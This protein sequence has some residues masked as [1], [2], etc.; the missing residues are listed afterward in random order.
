MIL[1]K[2]GI[3]QFVLYKYRYGIGMFALFVSAIFLL[4]IRLDTLVIGISNSEALQGLSNNSLADIVKNPLYAPYKIMQWGSIKI[5]G[6]SALALR[7][8]SV[9]FAAASVALLYDIFRHWHKQRI[10]ILGSI[11]FVTSSWFLNYARLGISSISLA[12]FILILLWAGTR[13]HHAPVRRWP[14]LIMAGTVAVSLYV[15]YMLYFLIAGVALH[16]YA[17]KKYLWHLNKK[18]RVAGLAILIVIVAPL[19]YAMAIDTNLIKLYF[20]VPLDLPSLKEYLA[21]ISETIGHIFWR[22]KENPE[23]HL[24]E[25]PMLDIF[26][27]TMA[28][29]G[30]YQYEKQLNQHRTKW[31]F[32]G[33]LILVLSLSLASLQETFIALA[34][35]TYIFAATGVV[36][37]LVQWYEI[38]PRNPV[39][40]T[41]GLIPIIML[42]MIVTSYH[43]NRY[44][45][46]WARSPETKAVFNMDTAALR[47]AIIDSPEQEIIVVAPEDQH[48]TIQFS[49]SGLV[50]SVIILTPGDFFNSNLA[51]EATYIYTG[52]EVPKEISKQLTPAGEVNSQ[53]TND[54]LSYKKFLGPD[55]KIRG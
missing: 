21:S 29:L 2:G 8:P 39:A 28:A 33:S 32:I 46:A 55:V 40:R 16:R 41:V 43:A 53:R 20:G 36:T 7:I 15:P 18:E 35:L 27:A 14:F 47:Q 31:L 13:L 3:D 38:F 26:T 9:I 4:T 25:L 52:V 30:V 12:F 22:S 34:P 42:M 49:T 10:A 51:A 17:V 23:L 19:V 37:L 11:L 54:P 45:L 5:L 50:R 24:G 48:L 1:S 6:S 44:F